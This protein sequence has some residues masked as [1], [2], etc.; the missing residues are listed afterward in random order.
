MSQKKPCVKCVLYI[1]NVYAMAVDR[2]KP[3]TTENP[4]SL[5]FVYILK[6]LTTRV[7]VDCIECLLNKPKTSKKLAS[8][9]FFLTF[10]EFK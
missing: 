8:Y 9:F 2:S 3:M 10:I 1:D 5:F 6:F 4:F 7:I